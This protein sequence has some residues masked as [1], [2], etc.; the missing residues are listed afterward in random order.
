MPWQPRCR[1]WPRPLRSC[2]SHCSSAEESNN[3]E[4]QGTP[5]DPRPDWRQPVGRIGH[6]ELRRETPQTSPVALGVHGPRSDQTPI[7]I[8]HPCLRV[9]RFCHSIHKKSAAPTSHQRDLPPAESASQLQ[10]GAEGTSSVT[11]P[12]TS[13]TGGTRAGMGLVPARGLGRGVSTWDAN[14][15]Q[16]GE[17]TSTNH[18]VP[19]TVGQTS[20]PCRPASPG[21][22]T[23]QPSVGQSW[24]RV[25]EDPSELTKTGISGGPTSDPGAHP[26]RPTQPPEGDT[27]QNQPAERRDALED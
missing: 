25:G 7:A 1:S 23:A 3:Q 18:A 24:P 19:P 17:P 12:G 5:H 22:S 11:V 2:L 21:G 15:A 26:H 13:T 9:S 4:S 16:A 20:T 27:S 14:A 6:Q 8:P 10:D